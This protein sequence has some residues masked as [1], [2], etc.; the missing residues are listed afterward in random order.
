MGAWG[1]G[2]YSS[3]MAMDLK[4]AVAAIARLPFD[5]ARLIELLA[6]AHPDAAHHPDDEEHTTFWLVLADQ[7][8]KRGMIAAMAREKALAIIESG[9]DLRLH[10][11][12]GLSSAALRK[13]AKLL[14]DLRGRLVSTPAASKPR[15]VMK[16]PQ[17]YLLETGGVYVY[18]TRRGVPVNPYMPAENFER[19]AWQPDGYGLMIVLDRG[20]AFDFLAW[21]QPLVAA[22]ALPARPDP[23]S[24]DPGITWVV[25][26]PGTLSASHHK[27]LALE[28]IGRVELDATKVDA[29]L[30]PRRHVVAVAVA[31]I[32][33]SNALAVAE[34]SSPLPK[35]LAG[36][37][38]RTTLVGLD[39]ILA[40]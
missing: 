11:Q 12:L 1:A 34:A 14:E 9:M 29:L 38:S 23:G 8:D 25:H 5:E 13:R 7:L 6:D 20:R 35:V 36:M 40:L 19:G 22:R 2:L 17:P 18:P 24:L 15:K 37:P 4:A 27:K 21:Y 32:S 16:A 31:D 28:Q 10:E 39:G 3:D 33:I 26:H 30:G